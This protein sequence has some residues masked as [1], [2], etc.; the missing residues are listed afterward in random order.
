MGNTS[1]NSQETSPE[2]EEKSFYDILDFIS[3]YYILTM[4]FKSLTKLSEKEYCDNLVILTSDIIE[5]YFNDTQINYLAQR[6]KNGVEVNE[7]DTDNVIYFNKN[8]LNNLD[9]SNDKQKSIKKKR[10][11]IGIAKFYIKIAHIFSAIVMTVNPVY[12]Y[13]NPYTNQTMKAGLLEK[14]SIP[15]NVERSLKKLNICDNRIRAL[16][17]NEVFTNETVSIQPKV[18][19]MNLS[20]NKMQPKTLAEEPGIAELLSLYLDDKYDYST[21]KF[22]GMSDKTQHQYMKDLKLFYTAFTGNKTMPSDIKSFQDIKLR[23]YSKNPGCQGN[24]ALK[25]KQTLNKNDELFVKYAT[26]IQQMI[27]SAADNQSKLLKVINTLFIYVTDPFTGKKVVRVN[28]KLTEVELESASVKARNLILH[29]YIQCEE[30]YV[31]GV[32]LYEAIVES[33]ILETSLSQIETLKKE[34]KKLVN[35]TQKL[36]KPSLEQK[37]FLYKPHISQNNPYENQPYRNN[38]YEN[39]PYRNQPFKNNPYE[40]QPYRNNPYENQPYRNNP[41]EYES[42]ENDPY[43]DPY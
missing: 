11:C 27:Q 10:V 12:V 30:D 34:S 39:Q 28:P 19:D 6:I 26:H 23:D 42:Y 21:G 8:N 37:D 18:C 2:E 7:M 14:D 41:Y 25:M 35:E 17:N 24:S 5:R 31:K 40:N 32:Q 9:V 43:E 20:E 3:S 13:K 36:T 29:L 16:K 22:L 33:K 4:D 1:S 38:P 15:K